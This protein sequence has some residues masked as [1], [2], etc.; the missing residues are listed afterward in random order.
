[1]NFISSFRL[2]LIMSLALSSS[3]TL[4]MELWQFLSSPLVLMNLSGRA[5]GMD[6]PI[7]K[8]DEYES[9]VGSPMPTELTSLEALQ[10]YAAYY[11]LARNYAFVLKGSDGSRQISTIKEPCLRV[12]TVD[13]DYG[14]PKAHARMA[15]IFAKTDRLPGL[16]KTTRVADADIY[17]A[18]LPHDGKHADELRKDFASFL[19]VNNQHVFPDAHRVL[20]N[21][22]KLLMAIH[23]ESEAFIEQVRMLTP[24]SIATWM[25]LASFS[26]EE[27]ENL[28]NKLQG[29][30]NDIT[31]KRLYLEHMMSHWDT[32]QLL[33]VIQLGEIFFD[34]LTIVLPVIKDIVESGYFFPDSSI[35]GTPLMDIG[36]FFSH[37]QCP[38]RSSY[39][40][41]LAM[42]TL[43][44][45][46]VNDLRTKANLDPIPPSI[47][48]QPD[49]L[50]KVFE[51]DDTL[52]PFKKVHAAQELEDS[53]Q[54]IM[55]SN[56]LQFKKQQAAGRK[57]E[58]SRRRARSK[59]SK[60]MQEVKKNN[61]TNQN[62]I[63][64]MVEQISVG[65]DAESRMAK[66]LPKLAQKDEIAEITLGAR[67]NALLEKHEQTAFANLFAQHALSTAQINELV[68]GVYRALVDLSRYRLATRFLKK[69]SDTR[70][71][72]V[73]NIH[74]PVAKELLQRRLVVF[75]TLDI[76]HPEFTKDHLMQDESIRR[77]VLTERVLTTGKSN[78]GA[79]NVAELL[80]NAESVVEKANQI[81]QRRMLV[82]LAHSWHRYAQEL[83]LQRSKAAQ[84]EL[85][86]ITGKI[87]ALLKR[88]QNLPVSPLSTGVLEAYLMSYYLDIDQ[89]PLHE[90]LTYKEFSE[91]QWRAFENLSYSKKL[92][93]FELTTITPHFEELGKTKICN[94]IFHAMTNGEVDD[95]LIIKF[96]H[97]VKD[98]KLPLFFRWQEKIYRTDVFGGSRLRPNLTEGDYGSVVAVS[99][100]A[101]EFFRNWF[102]SE[103]SFWYGQRA[104][105][106]ASE[107]NTAKQLHGDIF[108]QTI[109]DEDF[110]RIF[111]N[112]I[113][114]DGFGYIKAS[115]AKKLGLKN[116]TRMPLSSQQQ[117]EAIF[118][119]TAFQALHG[120]ESNFDAARDLFEGA[121]KRH[122]KVTSS[123]LSND[124]I[125]NAHRCSVPKITAVGIPVDGEQLVLPATSTW[126]DF[127]NTGTMVGRNPYSARSLQ[128]VSSDGIIFNDVLNELQVFQYTLTGL[129]GDNEISGSF[130]K[131]LLAVID[132]KNWPWEFANADMVV[133]TKDEK[134]NQAWATEE[135]KKFAQGHARMIKMRGVLFVTKELAKR[136]LAGIPPALTD[137]LAGDFDGDDYDFL[138]CNGYSNVAALVKEESATA[139]LNPK[140]R[141]SFTP[142]E[143]VGNYGRILALRK[144]ILETWNGIINRFYNLPLKQRLELAKIM[145]PSN[146]LQEW[147]EEE[148][149]QKYHD[150][151]DI[152]TVEIQVGIKLGED[153]FKTTVNSERVMKRARA[154]ER[155]LHSLGSKPQLPYGTNLKK[156]LDAGL[157]IKTAMKDGLMPK[158]SANLYD[159]AS[160]ALSRYLN[161]DETYESYLSDEE[162]TE[163]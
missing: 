53:Q 117:C 74:E 130:F 94:S 28:I 88:A 139:I 14:V 44:Q 71:Y 72:Q 79:N 75:L 131:G 39:L 52:L 69:M 148:E 55:N 124:D 87:V 122:E 25:R 20:S 32:T 34:S 65:S 91:I 113:V 61:E 27:K 118:R 40:F 104:F 54:W 45:D 141:K 33:D 5:G 157:D 22:L 140:M 137:K 70:L 81:D 145:A 49:Y 115:K 142:R 109:L 89:T 16:A 95:Y 163:Q 119:N 151:L 42:G 35:K 123:L 93:C 38:L 30:H 50:K 105:M 21:M 1:M 56:I 2:W 47:F 8:R 107:E 86:D 126:Q 138:T 29:I 158:T 26:S 136:Q 67:V 24:N 106:P 129:Y 132:D 125:A 146:L 46:V 48:V 161:S 62:L 37:R 31:R 68:F 134:L 36:R 4:A 103:E 19:L 101:G 13:N 12:S 66:A 64:N 147:L 57:L 152:I 135:H 98:R 112:L 102:T 143:R 127:V 154:Y 84:S 110:T 23:A 43:L 144:P 108:V 17:F 3:E 156:K 73:K 116:A 18:I 99:L 133:S 7:I 82:N 162:N 78:L 97:A 10:T 153:I 150:E 80:L 6:V 9:L 128:H 77:Q 59:K 76:V 83:E 90:P 96:D 41:D 111:G 63:P 100:R 149:W 160:R 85:G 51:I 11:A 121:V 155:V 92:P 60:T 120:Y 15:T 58:E 159:K 114:H